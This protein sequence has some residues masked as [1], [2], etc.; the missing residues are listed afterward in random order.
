MMVA[1]WI[2]FF[3]YMPEDGIFFYNKIRIVEDKKV[4]LQFKSSLDLHQV[5]GRI[6][7]DLLQTCCKLVV[8]I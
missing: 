3:F 7:S 2:V 6:C 1:E 5:T 8:M 4:I